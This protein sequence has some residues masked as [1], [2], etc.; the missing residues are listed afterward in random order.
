MADEFPERVGELNRG[1]GQNRGPRQRVVILERIGNLVCGTENQRTGRI[2]NPVCYA[3]QTVC[4][5]GDCGLRASGFVAV[6]RA[7]DR[8]TEPLGNSAVSIDRVC[9]ARIVIGGIDVIGTDRRG[10]L[11]R[12]IRVLACPCR[13]EPVLK[14]FI[15]VGSVSLLIDIHVAD[16]TGVIVLTKNG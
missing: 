3:D 1:G 9:S 15:G 14:V 10:V 4:H 11:T 2:G 16:L 12:G 5:P 7:N 8:G 13:S 6:K